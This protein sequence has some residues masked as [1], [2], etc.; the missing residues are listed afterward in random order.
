[1]QGNK[2]LED[3]A[4]SVNGDD[5]THRADVL[6]EASEDRIADVFSR[7]ADTVAVLDGSRNGPAPVDPWADTTEKE[8]AEDDEVE[9]ESVPLE[10]Q[11]GV[12]D[13][14]R[15]YLREIGKVFLLSG[16][17]EKRLARA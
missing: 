9:K 11:E 2:P 7:L 5:A 17:D 4:L 3:I 14:V 16:P 12:D 13:P 10:D 1:M 8:E 6:T 15:M